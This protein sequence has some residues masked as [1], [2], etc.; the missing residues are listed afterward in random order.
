MQ[1]VVLCFSRCS[2]VIEENADSL[3]NL[4]P[5]KKHFWLKLHDDQINKEEA[6][7]A[8]ASSGGDNDFAMTM[9]CMSCLAC[10]L[11]MI[12]YSRTAREV[13]KIRSGGEQR[14]LNVGVYRVTLLNVYIKCNLYV[15]LII[16]MC[17]C[18]VYL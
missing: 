12:Y 16:Y 17:I 4:H 1:I 15:Y 14:F 6:A 3:T 13:R 2:D 9:S 18:L 5:I 10:N 11:K 8:E 7:G